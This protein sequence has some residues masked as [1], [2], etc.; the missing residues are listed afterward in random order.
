[1]I[2]RNELALQ[3]TTDASYYIDPQKLQIEVAIEAPWYQC[4]HCM[5]LRPFVLVSHCTSC[6][7]AEIHALNPSTSDYIRARKGFWRDPVSAASLERVEAALRRISV[8]EHTAQLSNRDNSKV[9]ATTTEEFELR[10][11]DIRLEDRDRPI[12]VLSCT[13]TM[14]VGVDIGSLVAVGLRNVPPQR[15]N[16]QQRAGRA[17]RRGASVSSVLTYAQNGPHDSFFFANPAQI[18]SGQPRNPDVKIDNPKI[19]K[20]HVHSYL[21]QTYFHGF[22]DEHGIAVGGATSA[23][24]RAL[25]KAS[26]FFYVDVGQVPTFAGFKA[27]CAKHVLPKDE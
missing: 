5:T 14:E 9:H 15:E 18:V 6:G 1:M 20:R 19:A 11:R 22:M 4:A 7:S 16:Y 26:D 12:D 3:S 27:W 25:G 10:F 8:E 24:Y 23:L 17:G 2:L 21:L 13:T